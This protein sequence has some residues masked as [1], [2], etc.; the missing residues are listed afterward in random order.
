MI[1]NI[2][3]PGTVEYITSKLGLDSKQDATINLGVDVNPI[4]NFQ[5]ATHVSK[6]K[7]L[8]ALNVVLISVLPCVMLCRISTPNNQKGDN[9][10]CTSAWTSLYHVNYMFEKHVGNKKY[11]GG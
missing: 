4:A 3:L 10:L 11:Y 5:L 9:S 1:A 8:K 2:R 6:F 7:I